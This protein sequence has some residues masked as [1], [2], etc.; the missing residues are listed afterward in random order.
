MYISSALLCTRENRFDLIP[1]KI[2]G[3]ILLNLEAFHAFEGIAL[4]K[5]PLDGVIVNGLKSFQSIVQGV[6]FET[7][8]F[9]FEFEPLGMFSCSFTQVPDAR[10]VHELLKEHLLICDC[11]RSFV[12]LRPR[13]VS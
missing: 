1:G 12:L 7:I 11:G 13:E 8:S 5:T 6:R 2:F 3:R 10:E 4:R 9:S